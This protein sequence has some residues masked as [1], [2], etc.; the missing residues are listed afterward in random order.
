M[1]GR[2]EEIDSI[3][4]YIEEIINK[5]NEIIEELYSVDLAESLYRRVIFFYYNS[6]EIRENLEKLLIEKMDSFSINKES[7]SYFI[8]VLKPSSIKEWIEKKLP[9]EEHPWTKKADFLSKIYEAFDDN[10]EDQDLYSFLV[11]E[12]KLN[13][14][15]CW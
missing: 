14:H 5:S 8:F 6:P 3:L 2:G 9:L 13:Q 4:K 10:W 12:K 15:N 7:A 11:M 1:E